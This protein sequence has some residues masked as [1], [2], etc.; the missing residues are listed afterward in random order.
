MGSNT[1]PRDMR[2]WIS[3]LDG[4]G[5]TP[6]LVKEKDL[7]AKIGVIES[8]GRVAKLRPA[9]PKAVSGS[10]AHDTPT[11]AWSSGP[12]SLTTRTPTP[13]R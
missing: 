2:T 3:E 10:L 5:T 1:Q 9:R 13:R 12:R 4:A 7:P 6:G 11:P 8:K